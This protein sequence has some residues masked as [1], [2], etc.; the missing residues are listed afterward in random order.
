MY[1]IEADFHIHHK[2]FLK[3]TIDT[4][5]YLYLVSPR[6]LLPLDL[7]YSEEAKVIAHACLPRALLEEN[8]VI[9]L[10]CAYQ[11]AGWTSVTALG[12]KTKSSK[13]MCGLVI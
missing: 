6:P 3:V 11:P 12:K 9:N 4:H 7:V 13:S 2:R 10:R 5:G 8:P 1:Q